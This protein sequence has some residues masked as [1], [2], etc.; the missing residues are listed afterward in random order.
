MMELEAAAGAIGIGAVG[1]AVQRAIAKCFEFDLQIDSDL[2][3]H[4][5]EGHLEGEFE[6]HYQAKVELN[7]ESLV[8]S[9][10]HFTAHG[11]NTGKWIAASGKETELE[12][13]G[14]NE[15]GS[16]IEGVD[17][18]TEGEPGV[19]EASG[20]LSVPVAAGELPDVT[21]S[22][23]S[24]ATETYEIDVRDPQN[25]N[26]EA[27]FSVQ[28]PEWWFDT[29]LSLAQAGGTSSEGPGGPI[30]LRLEPP[31]SAKAP[32]P[33]LIGEK[34]IPAAEGRGDHGTTTIRVIHDPGHILFPGLAPE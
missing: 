8:P 33:D 9:A 16:T 30:S 34:T 27:G 21:V 31:D 3:H 11:S 7:Y 12:P 15:D 28:S 13:G 6:W 29:W 14:C 2:H 10:T 32:P 23:F 22:I 18:L 17:E 4:D 26:C 20:D 5:E 24:S 19:V 1:D 25:S